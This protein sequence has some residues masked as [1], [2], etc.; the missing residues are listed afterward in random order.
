LCGPERIETGWWDGDPVARDYFIAVD[1]EGALLW[2][3]RQR[4]PADGRGDGLLP[5]GAA[6]EPAGPPCWPSQ[7]PSPW[8]SWYLHGW[9]G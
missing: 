3:F 5:N 1:A 7:Q 9:F 4:L 2:V 6:A 8:S